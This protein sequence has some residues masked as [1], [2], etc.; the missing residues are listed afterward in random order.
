MLMWVGLIVALIR[1]F[2][3]QSLRRVYER[4]RTLSQSTSVEKHVKV[5]EALVALVLKKLD[6]HLLGYFLGGLKTEIQGVHP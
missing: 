2:E 6:E 3:E 1:V 5:F 4:L